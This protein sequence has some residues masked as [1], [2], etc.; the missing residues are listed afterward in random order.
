MRP[1]G[2]SNNRRLALVAGL[3]LAT[4]CGVGARLIQLHVV[5]R[6]RYLAQVEGARRKVELVAGRRGDIRDARGD[7]LASTRTEMTLA[8]DGW[9][10]LEKLDT[11][12]T[13]E[14]RARLELAER[15]KRL[16]LAEILGLTATQIEASF[17]PQ[18]R[19]VDPLRDTRDGER[20]GQVKARWVKFREGVDEAD[21][22]EIAKLKIAGLSAE[23]TYRRAY[24]HGQLAAHVVGFVNKE[25]V[26]G[27][28]VEAFAD[29]YLRGHDGW[30]ES[31]KDGHRQELAQ[32]RSREVAPSDGWEV[33]LSLDTAVQ[34]IVEE[35]LTALVEKFRPEKA[36]I[37]VSDPHTGFLLALANYPTFDLN[38]YATAPAEHQRNIAT[39]YLIEPGSTFKIVPAA[40][41]LNEGLV[42]LDTR[43]DCSLSSIFFEGRERRLMRD[44]HR[45]DHPLV[46]SEIIAKSSNVG[47][48]QLGMK[49]GSRGLYDYARAFGY[50]ERSGYPLGL[51]EAG[52]FAD[53]AKWSGTDITRIPAGYTIAATPLQVHYSMAVIASGGRLM[54]PQIIRQVRDAR[55]EFVYDF[56]PDIRRQVVSPQTAQVLANMLQ[57]VASPEGT[58]RVAAIPGFE[59]AGKTG[60]AQKLI[61]GRYSAHNHVGSFVGFLPASRPRVSITVVVDDGK[62]PGGGTGYGSVVAAPSF[63]RIAEQL[64]QYMDIKPV[65]VETTP[66]VLAATGGGAVRR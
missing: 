46:L 9:A 64:I 34:H 49:L 3:L 5:Q 8:A 22:V 55:G 19:P 14:R 61:A 63:K 30:I 12:R 29:R 44:D 59:V 43:F 66:T 53:P 45:A 48:T 26:P 58:A 16:R 1:R 57:K 41:A 23:R 21:H 17:A 13:P 50:G 37:I 56:A 36:T 2:F 40:G 62:P 39:G 31:E 42:T 47:A 4:F 28:G 51:E 27:A 54:R 10:L 20:D 65:S 35:E 52:I 7:L 25:G 33:A 18:W 11:E 6:D 32:F 24:P 60:T 38:R 15:E